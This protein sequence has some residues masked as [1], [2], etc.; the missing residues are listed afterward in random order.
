MT[1]ETPTSPQVPSTSPRR[2]GIPGPARL[3]L[4]RQ[5]P[6]RRNLARR[7]LARQNPDRPVTKPQLHYQEMTVWISTGWCWSREATNCAGVR[8]QLPALGPLLASPL[9]ASPPAWDAL[10]R[11]ATLEQGGVLIEL[12]GPLPAEARQR[13]EQADHLSWA[14]ASLDELPLDCLPA[15]PWREL[16]VAPAPANDLEW[17]EAVASL[18]ALGTLGEDVASETAG[19][20]S[21]R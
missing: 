15:V 3:D 7:N 4:V 9:P 19:W 8:Q 14:L 1:G 13:I 5:N 16:A 18:A 12:D 10:V 17:A 6:G 21:V 20:R 2:P 11:Q